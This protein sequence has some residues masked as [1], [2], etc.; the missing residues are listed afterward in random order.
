MTETI[1]VLQP[2][3]AE[4]RDIGL[5]AEL[6]NAAPRLNMDTVIVTSHAASTAFEK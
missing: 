1:L 5:P 3:A 2:V 4:L 6:L